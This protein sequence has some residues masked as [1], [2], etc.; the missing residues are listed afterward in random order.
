M[1][2]TTSDSDFAP[3][4]DLSW[5]RLSYGWLSC[6]VLVALSAAFVGWSIEDQVLLQVFPQMFKSID[7]WGW[8]YAAVFPSSVWLLATLGLAYSAIPWRRRVAAWLNI[9]LALIGGLLV[10]LQDLLVG[11][12]PF[13]DQQFTNEL[14]ESVQASIPS[15]VLLVLALSG[16]L[17]VFN[18]V[19]LP[20]RLQQGTRET[21][22][23]VDRLYGRNRSSIVVFLVF[24][25]AAW[26]MVNIGAVSNYV[27]L[28]LLYGVM[29]GGVIHGL[30]SGLS[31]IGVIVGFDGGW[32]CRV[33][34]LRQVSCLS[35]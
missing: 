35:C 3:V 27:Y 13:V 34:G 21:Q 19:I 18:R 24:L 11:N 32:G 15:F 25:G 22:A 31:W 2:E 4:V 26:I 30:L 16:T 28:W 5:Q 17:L 20:V 12:T 10:G 6:V 29:F 7:F 14:R 1:A 9:S 33:G 8:S 23:V